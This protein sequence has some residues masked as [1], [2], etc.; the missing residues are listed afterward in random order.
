MVSTHCSRVC[1][2]RLCIQNTSWLADDSRWEHAT[3]G[4]VALP[5]SRV[6]FAVSARRI[7]GPVF[8]S[9]T[10]NSEGYSGQIIEQ[11]L[12][13][14]VKYENEYGFF[15]QEAPPPLSDLNATHSKWYR[16]AHACCKHP[17]AAFAMYVKCMAMAT[18]H[19]THCDRLSSLETTP[20]LSAY[21]NL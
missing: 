13:F 21:I 12:L 10:L 1:Q 8:V 9:N 6:L 17:S 19:V 20:K 16:F 3:R 14:K 4:A 11:F 5:Q 15:Q 2:V 7:I 18:W